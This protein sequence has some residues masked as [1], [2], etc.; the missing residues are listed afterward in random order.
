MVELREY[1][2]TGQQPAIQPVLLTFRTDSETGQ[3]NNI[4]LTTYQL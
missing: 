3:T 2:L 4:I 1:S